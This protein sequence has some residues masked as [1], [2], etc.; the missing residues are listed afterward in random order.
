MKSKILYK[1]LLVAFLICTALSCTKTWDTSI[2]LGVNSTRINLS[3]Q[4]EGD[5]V[6]PVYTNTLWTASVTAGESWLTLD[7]AS[8]NGRGFMDVHYATNNDNPARIGKILISAGEKSVTVN[9]VQ[10][11][12]ARQASSVS[13]LE[14]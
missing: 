9:I 11:G 4:L 1:V 2:E 14:L 10:S 13:D 3:S 5:F 8:G 12:M 7:N 6:I